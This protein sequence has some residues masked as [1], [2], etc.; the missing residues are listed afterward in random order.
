V[1]SL[2][3]TQS[4]QLCLALLEDLAEALSATKAERGK[5]CAAEAIAR[6]DALSICTLQTGLSDLQQ[7]LLQAQTALDAAAQDR[8]ELEQAQRALSHHCHTRPS[9]GQALAPPSTPARRA[10]DAL[11]DASFRTDADGSEA[12]EKD[13]TI[14]VVSSFDLLSLEP[15]MF[16]ELELTCNGISYDALADDERF[17]KLT[18][19]K[20]RRHGILGKVAH[21]AYEG[22]VLLHYHGA[23]VGW[24]T[25][26]RLG[27]VLEIENM[28]F[29]GDIFSN[30]VEVFITMLMDKFKSQIPA[31]NITAVALHV[32]EEDEEFIQQLTNI[33]HQGACFEEYPSPDSPTIQGK[34]REKYAHC[35]GDWTFINRA[36]FRRPS[37]HR[38][39]LGSLADWKSLHDPK[40]LAILGEMKRSNAE[41]EMKP[42]VRGGSKLKPSPFAHLPK[43]RCTLKSTRASSRDV[44]HESTNSELRQPC[45]QLQTLWNRLGIDAHARTVHE[46]Y[47]A[48]ARV[49]A[50]EEL[51]KR[52]QARLVRLI[53]CFLF[54]VFASLFLSSACFHLCLCLLLLS[55]GLIFLTFTPCY[56]LSLDADATLFFSGKLPLSDSSRRLL[57]RRPLFTLRQRTWLRRRHH[58]RSRSSSSCISRNCGSY[59]CRCGDEQRGR[60]SATA[61]TGGACAA[62][63]ILGALA[64]FAA[65]AGCAIGCRGCGSGFMAPGNGVAR[66][67]TSSVAYSVGSLHRCPIY[68]QICTGASRCT[69]SWSSWCGEGGRSRGRGRAAGGLQGKSYCPRALQRVR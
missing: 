36:F 29:Y 62:E 34:W 14:D 47:I 48:K 59:W 20:G 27:N 15:K 33:K 41:G 10:I 64:A 2:D 66:L 50:E 17:T 65:G 13:L 37:C 51:L 45:T 1:Q 26:Q 7:D 3:P 60:G 58:C 40:S 44:P 67:S 22:L 4:H 28:S 5:V 8:Q 42:R 23:V 21:H 39:F 61:Q 54:F 32:N 6:E 31:T 63:Y 30:M 25:F 9:T 18:V 53:F 24:C 68:C 12:E 49:R 38:P 11:L 52:L 57:R 19:S 16:E 35:A 55:F 69:A 56:L 43:D 46:E